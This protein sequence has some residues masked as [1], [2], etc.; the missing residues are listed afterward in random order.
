MVG[1]PGAPDRAAEGLPGGPDLAH[2]RGQEAAKRAL[3]V[4]AAGGHS[5]LLAGP[6]GAGKT[7]LARCLPGLLPPLVDDEASEV[8]DL[9]GR[10]GLHPPREGRRPFRRVE[11]TLR[12]ADLVGTPKKPGEAS[13]A[14]NG[15]LLLDDLRT[16]RSP[17]LQAISRI[18]EEGTTTLSRGSHSFEFPARFQLIATARLCPCGHRGGWSPACRCTLGELRLYWRPLAATILE[19]LDLWVEVPALSLSE[20]R[21]QIGESSGTVA[22]RVA[23]ARSL[24]ADRS[25]GR[26]EP[27]P[28]GARIGADLARHFGLDAA[29]NALLDAAIAKLALSGRGLARV[30]RVSRTIADLSGGG[31]IQAVHLAEAIQYRTLQVSEFGGRALGRRSARDD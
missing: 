14:H 22:R 19:A 26:A 16:H 18:V 30:L 15:V 7:M 9:H 10:A 20:L 24:Q 4:A 29:G 5:L 12:L 2:V 28:H 21:A 25:R 6:M 3:E 8:A 27:A 1:L 31:A 13:L 23:H 11:P 17:A